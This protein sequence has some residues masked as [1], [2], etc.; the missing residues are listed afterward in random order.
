MAHL[1]ARLAALRAFAEELESPDFD[2]GHWYD[3]ERRQTPD[4][5]VWTMPW[6]EPS[7]RARAFIGASG[8]NGW[9]E[10]FDW[11]TWAETDESKPFARTAPRSQKRLRINSSVCSRPSSARTD[12]V[13][14]RSLGHSRAG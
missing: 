1:P 12:S 7:D 13:R 4:G 2:A 8:A 5:D 9:V 14:A 10:P 11:M 6:F 3:S